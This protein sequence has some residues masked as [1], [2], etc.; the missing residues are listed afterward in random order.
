[1]APK[2]IVPDEGAKRRTAKHAI[3]FLVDLLKERA[4]VEFAGAL[5]IFE[6][7]VLGHVEY[8]ELEH[9]A[10]LALVHQIVQS[11]P[12]CLELLKVRGMH[13]LV[14]LPGEQLIDIRDPGVDRRLDIFGN[15][16][17]ALHDLFDERG[18]LLARLFALLLVPADASL[19]DDPF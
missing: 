10:G 17:R 4:L 8:P 3:L 6:E 5:Q 18:D 16:H 2:L 1:M 15:A 11:P 14:E 12:R 13:D 7:I 19:V 9:R